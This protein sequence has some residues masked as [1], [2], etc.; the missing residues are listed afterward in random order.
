MEETCRTATEPPLVTPE[1]LLLLLLLLLL[2][3]VARWPFFLLVHSCLL[4]KVADAL[5]ELV[6]ASAHLVDASDDA[7]RH[8]LEPSLHLV[9]EV[10]D[11]LGQVC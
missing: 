6:D 5:L 4:N 9:E 8:G 10:L 3:A 11:K 1:P 2:D 7:V